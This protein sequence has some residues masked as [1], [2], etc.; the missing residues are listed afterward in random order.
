[1][2]RTPIVPF[3]AS[4]QS[5]EAGIW[6]AELISHE[7]V[8]VRADSSVRP[9]RVV[10]Q[11]TQKAACS[12]CKAKSMCTASETM[13]KEVEAEAM[14]PMQVGDA[15]EVMVRKQL[16]WKAVALA[17]VLP[18]LLLL[19]LVWLLPRWIQSE[20]LVGTLALLAL[21]PYYL[22]LHLFDHHFKQEYRF[23]AQKR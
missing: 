11:I 4:S 14:E 10:V 21:A 6:M 20:A 3:F 23:F 18:F 19:L 22:L 7:G 5:G 15:V 13:V 16:G 9:M 8:V 2:G 12:A 1:M 17:F